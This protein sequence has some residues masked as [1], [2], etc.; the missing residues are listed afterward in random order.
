MSWRRSLQLGLLLLSGAALCGALPGEVNGCDTDLSDE[1]A[2]DDY[3][4]DRCEALCERVVTCGLYL[5]PEEPPE[6]ATIE[7]LCQQDCERHYFCANPQLCNAELYDPYP[8]VSIEE[9]EAC[10]GD[11]NDLSCDL[12]VR[13]APECGND[14]GQCPQ[15]ETCTGEVLCDPPEWE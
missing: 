14:F 11:W 4:R 10:L 5:P 7:S 2:H 13:G 12:L 3:C 1:V 9:A 8:Y 15:I 6:D